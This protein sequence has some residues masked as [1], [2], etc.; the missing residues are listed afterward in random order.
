[1][2]GEILRLK[3]FKHYQRVRPK[4]E[5]GMLW[6]EAK[7]QPGKHIVVATIAQ[8]PEDMELN[9]AFIEERMKLLGWQKL[10][11]P[12]EMMPLGMLTDENV[13]ENR[14]MLQWVLDRIASWTTARWDQH[15]RY[16]YGD[17]K[18][19]RLLVALAGHGIT[20]RK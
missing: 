18:V 11:S 14:D 2:T 20:V 3:S 19:N 9:D 15:L 16:E 12:G 17:E 13:R 10:L 1:M 8:V 4:G 5:S 6:A 7:A